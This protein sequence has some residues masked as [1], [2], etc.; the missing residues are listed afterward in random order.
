MTRFVVEPFTYIE[1]LREDPDVAL[2]QGTRGSLLEEVRR[3]WWS[4]TKGP[5]ARVRPWVAAARP[6][7]ARGGPATRATAAADG[8][9]PVRRRDSDLQRGARRLRRRQLGYSFLGQKP[10]KR[11]RAERERAM[12]VTYS[13]ALM[14]AAAC[15]FGAQADKEREASEWDLLRGSAGPQIEEQ[16]ELAS[17]A[18][19]EATR[20]PAPEVSQ[21]RPVPN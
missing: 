16:G 11:E 13:S 1:L 6:E 7:M 9:G 20:H 14:A 21:P 12:A 5:R 2:E 19:M 10:H 4:G 18:R 3:R 15:S 17:G 8:D